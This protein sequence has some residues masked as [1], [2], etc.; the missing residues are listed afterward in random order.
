M[1]NV[2][3]FLLLIAATLCGCKA[4][5]KQA[6]AESLNLIGR[7]QT[8][9]KDLGSQQAIEEYLF[10]D[11]ENI[12]MSI[13]IYHTYASI[14]EPLATLSL[15][16]TYQLS[17]SICTIT[18]DPSSLRCFPEPLPGWDLEEKHELRLVVIPDSESEDIIT[19]RHAD[20]FNPEE[21]VLYRQK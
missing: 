3:L 18:V 1:K 15:N 7:W 5:T 19:L 21:K 6:D 20:G 17:D 13:I 10:Q 2:Y 11:D 9:A 14:D 16:G 12:V 4:G 8:E